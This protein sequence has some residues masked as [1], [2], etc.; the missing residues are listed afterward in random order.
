MICS[1]AAELKRRRAPLSASLT[2]I[3]VNLH[4]SMRGL[5]AAR[6][7]TPRTIA[8]LSV[9]AQRWHG[10]C[11]P[12]A[13]MTA[14]I[15]SV[16]GPEVV[17]R[18]IQPKPALSTE[19]VLFAGPGDVTAALAQALD[20]VRFTASARFEN[21]G[22]LGEGVAA[23]EPH[24]VVIAVSERFDA[25]LERVAPVAG[26]QPTVVWAHSEER[27]LI[28][29][30]LAAGASA[31]VPSETPTHRINAVLAVARV[32]FALQSGLRA[33]L[34]QARQALAD[35]KLIDR[36]KGIL[37]DRRQLSEDD[38]YHLMRRVAMSQGKRLAEIARAIVATPSALQ[39]P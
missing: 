32:Q 21:L 24:A 18:S 36:A 27:R 12:H 16:R 29:R 8:R 33:D 5:Q 19:R 11:E 4:R 3:G 34:E 7:H 22:Y 17:R 35:R 37:M 9:C 30:A 15:D 20:P 6:H 23:C 14:I 28:E 25:D 1:R 39:T 31:F 38:A 2:V 26:L 13:S 10:A